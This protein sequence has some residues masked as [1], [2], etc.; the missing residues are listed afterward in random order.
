LAEFRA[1]FRGREVANASPLD[2]AQIRQVGIL[3]GARQAGP[4]ALSIR[5]I[6]LE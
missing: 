3:I 5:R 1:S 2:P 6:S 4:F